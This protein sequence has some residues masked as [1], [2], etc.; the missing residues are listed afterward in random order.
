[1]NLCSI[2][3]VSDIPNTFL[4]NSFTILNISSFSSTDFGS[5]NLEGSALMK[6]VHNTVIAYAMVERILNSAARLDSV[7][8]ATVL[9]ILNFSNPLIFS[10]YLRVVLSGTFRCLYLNPYFSSHSFFII[11][12]THD[13]MFFDTATPPSIFL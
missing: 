10:I 1:M 6:W 3:D 5:W 11:R 2:L 13:I 4:F 12:L 7:L 8:L 9:Y